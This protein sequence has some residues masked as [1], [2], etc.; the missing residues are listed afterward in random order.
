MVLGAE[1]GAEC[2][3]KSKLL[4]LAVVCSLLPA[5]ADEGP[6]IGEAA[7]PLNL[8]RLINAPA[9]ASSTWRSLQGKVVVVD[10]W[11]TWCGPCVQ[12]IPHWN[13][14]VRGFS[15]QPVQF[16][17]ITDENSD[18]VTQFLNR[19]PIAGWVGLEG[20]AATKQAY[21]I[22][23]IPT[24]VIVNQSGVVVAVTHPALLKPEH[25]HE[26]LTNGTSSLRKPERSAD[27]DE[28][29]TSPAT[30]PQFEIS[31]RPSPPLPKGHGF[32]CWSSGANEW[33]GEYADVRSALLNLFDVRSS[34]MDSP[35]ELPL[36]RYHFTI[37]LP[38]MAKQARDALVRE[39]FRSTF[40][41][42][43]QRADVRRD[44]LVMRKVS[45]RAPGLTPAQDSRRGGG[46]ETLGGLNLDT[47]TLAWTESYLEDWL[48]KVVIDETGDTNRYDI[49][50]RWKLSPAE[51]LQS[52]LDRAI[53]RYLFEPDAEREKKLKPDQQKEI[54]AFRGELA[55]AEVAK[56]S[57]ERQEQFRLWRAEMAKPEDNRFA[58]DPEAIRTAVFEQW[59]VKLEPDRRM[60]PGLVVK[61]T[62]KE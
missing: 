13:E 37:I 19:K 62:E 41:L 20:V 60:L 6:I 31:V 27:P 8:E 34:T 28:V 4:S 49:R 61:A 40:R 47:A 9:G 51:Q 14:L 45:A 54:A 55:D 21:R 5:C 26:V 44:V 18:V 33:K 59:G 10:F 12:S 2:C 36:G 7:P 32:D 25:I 48:G 39:M 42:D 50:L 46:G 16:I 53:L 11:A 43:A 15:N 17:A 29:E 52:S 58:P 1:P 3:M 35:A 23:G 22:S 38:N 24:S 56:F 30:R 57:P